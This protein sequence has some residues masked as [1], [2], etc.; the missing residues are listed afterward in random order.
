M[1][2][3]LTSIK[4]A[5]SKPAVNANKSSSAVGK[6]VPIKSAAAPAKKQTEEAS[7]NKNKPTGSAAVV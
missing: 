4:P 6:L 5:S 3:K 7:N 2:S 1:K